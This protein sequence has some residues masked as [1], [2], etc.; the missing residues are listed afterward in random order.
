MCGICGIINIGHVSDLKEDIM[1]MANA[2]KH[3]GPDDE[4]YFFYKGGQTTIY[5]GDDTFKN[6][7]KDIDIIPYLPSKHINS[8]KQ[9]L[10]QIALGYRRLAIIDVSPYGHQPMSFLNRYWIVFNGEIFNYLELKKELLKD[11]YTFISGSDTEIILAAYNKWGKDCVKQFNGMWAFVIIDLREN[12]IF[13]SRDRF[14]EKPLYFYL[15]DNTFIFSSEIKSILQHSNV[16]T[17]PNVTYLKSYLKEG[18]NAYLQETAFNNIYSFGTA[19]LLECDISEIAQIRKKTETYWTLVPNTKREKFTKTELQKYTNEYYKLLSSSVNLRLR[20]DVRI[21]A[22]LSG[23]LDSSSIVSLIDK[24]IKGLETF[25][26]V[27]SRANTQNIDESKYIKLIT[28]QFNLKSTF[29]EIDTKDV[30]EHLRNIVYIMDVPASDSAMSGWHVYKAVADAK[31][32]VTLDGQGAD[33]SLAGYLSYYYIFLYNA[34][35][36]NAFKSMFHFF[37][38][39]GLYKKLL[40]KIFM[41]KV[42]STLF[43]KKSASKLL[44]GFKVKFNPAF[45][46]NEQLAYD[47]KTNLATLLHYGDRLS[48][49]YSVESRSPFVDYRLM[50]FLASVPDV[51]KFHKGWSKYLAREA[52]K[53]ELPADVVWR[54][55]KMGFPN[56]NSVWFGMDHKVW[57]DETVKNSVFVNSLVKTDDIAK[58]L[59]T[60]NINE[61]M[62][63]LILALWYEIFFEQKQSISNS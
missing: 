22:T 52:F 42:F 18:C 32:K 3:R 16:K 48:M 58:T 12:I 61:I 35:L 28:K 1:A 10:A 17:T 5:G 62:R 9:V 59:N 36:I 19:Q 57:V 29:I 56:A 6:V 7:K 25:S 4:G 60:G 2:I 39:P 38:V 30:K 47:V 24:E 63:L 31:V 33:E 26:N 37:K 46:L 40:F 20:A 41:F 11:G 45:S 8:E 13:I 55:D 15:S 23:G 44:S 14:G 50:E 49:A 27:Y 54:T 51:Y 43:S 21:G 53:H 34:S